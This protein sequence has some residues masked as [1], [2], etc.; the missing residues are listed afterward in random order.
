DTEQPMPFRARFSRPRADS[1]CDACEFVRPDR[2]A[3]E[4]AYMHAR[5][6]KLGGY[7]PARSA[8]ADPIA[9]PAAA[10][11]AKFALEAASKEM[12][13]TVA[14]VR[15]VGSVLRDAAI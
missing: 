1:Q 4:M 2:E 7:L 10:A 3:P 12:S 13:T 8:T 11:F 15:M 14:F 6:E 5:R 9:A